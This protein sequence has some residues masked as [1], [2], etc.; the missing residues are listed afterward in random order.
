VTSTFKVITATS[1][2]LLL[3]SPSQSSRA[4]GKEND[5]ITKHLVFDELEEVSNFIKK[6]CKTIYKA[7]KATGRILYRGETS[8]AKPSLVS[9]KFDLF[10]E[11]TY[12]SK[13]AVD[14]FSIIDEEMKVKFPMSVRPKFAH[15]GTTALM[16]ASVWGP[17]CSIWPIDRYICMN[18]LHIIVT[19]II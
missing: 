4:L 10:D 3:F 7:S 2:F 18:I 8:I 5:L 14:Y 6:N 16:M 15:L 12:S 9:S 1:P 19:L 17:V 11:N 13:S